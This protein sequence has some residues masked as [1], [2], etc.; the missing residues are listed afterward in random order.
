MN[1]T[2]QLI[3]TAYKNITKCV[4]YLHVKCICSILL[5]FNSQSDRTDKIAKTFLSCGVPVTEI[6]MY[7][8]TSLSFHYSV[9]L[10]KIHT[11]ISTYHICQ[12]QYCTTDVHQV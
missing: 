2:A 12:A 1:K 4:H 6:K 9:T 11:S 3:R 7:I 10:Q 5:R 8:L